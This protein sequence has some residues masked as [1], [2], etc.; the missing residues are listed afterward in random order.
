MNRYHEGYEDAASKL[1]KV[2]PKTPHREC[3]LGVSVLVFFAFF[4]INDNEL[5][6]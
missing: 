2:F 4:N 5:R 6:N 3:L 1:Q